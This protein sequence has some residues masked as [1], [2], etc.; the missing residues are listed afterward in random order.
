MPLYEYLCTAC[1]H[2]FEH[3][4]KF[5]DPLV[6]VCPTCGSGPVEKLVSSP[7]IQ[8]KGAGWYVNDYAKAGKADSSATKASKDEDSSK[9]SEAA[10]TDKAESSG[11]GESSAKT[12]TPATKTDTAPAKPASSESK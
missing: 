5:S 12:D 3:I 6:S 7:A 10:K 8:F 4:Q 9:S 11:K 2:R 1:G